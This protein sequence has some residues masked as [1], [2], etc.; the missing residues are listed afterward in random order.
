M[1][2]TDRLDFLARVRADLGYRDGK[3]AVLVWTLDPVG[4]VEAS[5]HDADLRQ[6]IDLAQARYTAQ[7]PTL[8]QAA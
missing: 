7:H 3:Y 6:A 8:E 2:D 4:H 5:G 1:T